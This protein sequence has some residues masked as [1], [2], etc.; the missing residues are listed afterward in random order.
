VKQPS[1]EAES[2]FHAAEKRTSTKQGFSGM[3]PAAMFDFQVFLQR[4]GR[5]GST[6]F[7]CP[8]AH[9]LAEMRSISSAE[10]L[11]APVKITC[12]AGA[13]NRASRCVL[14]KVTELQPEDMVSLAVM[15][16][17]EDRAAQDIEL[18]PLKSTI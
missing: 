6:T 16:E 1:G 9:G 5:S 4:R 18:R 14:A 8:F 3:S 17:Y 2:G 10:V 15:T 12:E 11:V 7:C 13:V